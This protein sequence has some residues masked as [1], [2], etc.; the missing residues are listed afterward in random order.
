MAHLNYLVYKKKYTAVK[1]III[2]KLSIK[3]EKIFSPYLLNFPV[4]FSYLR[5][6]LFEKTRVDGF[7]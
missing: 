7:L 4:L 1:K 6:L 5:R 3:G 2:K